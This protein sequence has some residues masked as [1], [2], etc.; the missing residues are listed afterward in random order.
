MKTGKFITFEGGEGVG[1]STQVKLLAERLRSAG[2]EVV[3]TREPGGTEIGE[4]LRGLLLDPNTPDCDDL[5]EALLF[6]AARHNHLETII[7]PALAAGKWVLCDRFSDSS[8]VYQG[9]AGNVPVATLECLETMVVGADGPGLTI[10]IDL[11]PDVGMRRADERRQASQSEKSNS[12]EHVKDRFESRDTTFHHALRQGFLALAG[13]QP[14]RCVVVDGAQTA[15]H[16]ADQIWSIVQQRLLS[17]E[18]D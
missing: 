7:R 11:D 3:T 8:R 1:K 16:L 9:L 6:Y 14:E 18:A 13:E 15:E 4:A 10:V 12:S 2:C 5:T 17:A